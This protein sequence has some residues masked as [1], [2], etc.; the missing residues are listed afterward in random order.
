MSKVYFQPYVLGFAF[1]P[2]FKKV[3]LIRKNKPE[4]QA[5]N[6]NGIGG[7]IEPAESSK[8][9]MVREFFEE[10]AGKTV[11]DDWSKFATMQN[12]AWVVHCYKTTCTLEDLKTMESEEVVIV[13]V[14]NIHNEKTISNVPWLVLMAID[15]DN[16]RANLDYKD[17]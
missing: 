11:V 17:D 13:D 3:A 14:A 5:G 4:W 6:L 8:E 12:S 16:F 15:P 1:S 7:K 10:A 9:A 2:D